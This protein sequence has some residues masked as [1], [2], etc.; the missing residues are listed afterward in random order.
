VLEITFKSP[1]PVE[2]KL[3]A[4]A[5]REAYLNAALASKQQ[6][7]GKLAAWYNEQAEL[8]RKAADEAETKKA[9]Y[10]KETGIVLQANE[11]DMDS[12][13]LATLANQ[14]AMPNLQAGA[15][16]P[17]SSHVQLA[18]LDAQIEQASKNLGPNHP[19]MQS[20]RAQRAALAQVVAQEDAQAR[21]VAS[22]ESGAQAISRV[23]QDEKARVISQRD[24]VE[25]LRQLQAEVDL[26]RDQY[27]TTAARAAELA[28]QG[29]M[30]DPGLTPMGIVVAP[31]KP[32]FPNKPLMVGGAGALGVALGLGLALLLEL[33]NRRV[34]GVED[35]NLSSELKCI[36]VIRTPRPKISLIRRILGLGPPTPR[37]A[38][39]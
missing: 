9:A 27:K 6:N 22:G 16:G 26:R 7:A 10:E 23:L 1:D 11:T 25:K 17:S 8:A 13:R 39:A 21:K 38:V 30:T 33:L 34:R 35:L 24:K 19:E 15:A 3:G 12:G 29:S 5:L 37:P 36:G 2:A 14:L 31:T 18:Q 20:L 32:A 28:L 4:E